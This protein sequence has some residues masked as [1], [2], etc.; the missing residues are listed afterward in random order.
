M[1]LGFDLRGLKHLC[2]TMFGVASET[3]RRFARSVCRFNY[4]SLNSFLNL[5]EVE[6]RRFK[7]EDQETFLQHF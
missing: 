4:T 3:L 1:F 2:Q 5:P 7:T 6:L